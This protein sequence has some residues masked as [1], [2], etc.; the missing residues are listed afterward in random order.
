[1][2]RDFSATATIAA[3]AIATI[4]AL[5]ATEAALRGP[6]LD[7]FWTLQLADSRQGLA[8]LVRDGWLGD[9]HPP[10]FNAWATLLS[11]FGVTSIPAGRLISNLLAAGL[12]IL[13]SFRLAKRTPGQ[14]G[15][16]VALLLLTLSLTQAVDAFASY[17]SYF[18]Q[19]AAIAV[20][21]QVARHVASTRADLDLRKDLDLAVIAAVATAGAIAMHYV[22]GLF[23]GL[24]A[25]AVAVCALIRGLRRWAMLLLGSAGLS[26]L[27][28]AAIVLVQASNWAN[29]LDHSWIDIELDEAAAVP[30]ALVV[31]ALCH[32]PVALL[33]LCT[34]RR[35]FDRADRIFAAVIAVALIAGIALVLAIQLFQPIMVGRYLYAVPVLVCALMAVPAAHLV[36][37][38]LRFGLLAFVSIAVV[39]GHLIDSGLKPKWRESA[40]TIARLVQQCPTTQVFAASGWVLGPAAE[41]RAARREDPVFARAYRSLAGQYG[42]AV[43][44]L[45]QNDHAH[46]TPGRCPVLVWFEHTPNEAEDELQ[47]AVQDAGLTGLAEARLSVYRSA[48][49]FVVRAEQ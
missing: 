26:A 24:L 38:R 2:R 13:A 32:N 9:T 35:R 34:G 3:V 17:R 45:G 14:S 29:E 8:N 43:T 46:A 18:W 7:E 22:G 19:M 47:L 36:V 4:L 15:F 20:L 1:L 49:G 6:W 25:G 10:V 11:A 39:A 40:Q 30:I 33:G 44:F 48:T 16:A 31:A 41:T 21:A 42:Y 23:G 5:L 37:D 12:M 27:A 28:V